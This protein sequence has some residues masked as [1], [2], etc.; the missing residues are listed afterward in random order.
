M[1]ARIT[2][3][4]TCQLHENFSRLYYTVVM[5]PKADILFAKTTS[6]LLQK[7]TNGCNVHTIL[8]VRLT[9][10]LLIWQVKSKIQLLK[11]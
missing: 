9:S 11:A 6:E 4:I 10:N 8:A 2:Q 5:H 1:D 7:Q 3:I